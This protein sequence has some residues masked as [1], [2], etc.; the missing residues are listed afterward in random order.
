MEHL[1]HIDAHAR[2]VE[3]APD[4]TWSA[5]LTVARS[6][7]RPLPGALVWAWGLDPSE[8]RG[9]W[10]NPAPGASFPGFAVAEVDAPRLL[11]LR[12]R[13][14]FS[15]YELRFTIVP[16]GPGRVEVRAGSSGEFPG[17]LGAIYRGLVIG[18]RGHV[19]AV[20]RLLARIAE[21]A[22]REGPG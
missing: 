13:H 4:R 20:R 2:T 18:S 6:I 19:L 14:R 21:R 1:P 3:A 22:E 11:V 5:L 17:P 15:R 12:G 8:H 7:G 10:S 16:V 9:D